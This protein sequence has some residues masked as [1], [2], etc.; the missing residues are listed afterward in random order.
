MPVRLVSRM[1]QR[2]YTR[3]RRCRADP[4]TTVPRLYSAASPMF[5]VVFAT[6]HH[7]EAARRRLA[8][9][10]TRHTARRI[11]AQA[12]AMLWTSYGL[13]LRVLPEVFIDTAPGRQ[14]FALEICDGS[15]R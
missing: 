2:L 6:R 14:H 15:S 8:V 7:L 10:G 1:P 12:D 5:A 3:S 9:T 11:M 4:A 13:R